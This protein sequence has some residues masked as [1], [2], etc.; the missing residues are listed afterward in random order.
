MVHRKKKRLLSANRAPLAFKLTDI[1]LPG[2]SVDARADEILRSIEFRS[3]AKGAT[4]FLESGF[5]LRSD[6]RETHG[7]S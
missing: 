5:A 2:V 6:S 1:E 4:I 7:R 3:P